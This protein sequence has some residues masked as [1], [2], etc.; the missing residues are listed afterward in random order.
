MRKYIITIEKEGLY[1][2]ILSKNMKVLKFII[3]NH[4]IDGDEILEAALLCINLQWDSGL[5]LLLEKIET[6]FSRLTLTEKIDFSL[7]M[8]ALLKQTRPK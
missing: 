4:L 3:R 6:S 2:S 8:F 7:K 5:T 1:L